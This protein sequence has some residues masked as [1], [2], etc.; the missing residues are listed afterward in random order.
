[1]SAS[2]FLLPAISR[3][4]QAVNHPLLVT[5]K[6]SAGGDDD[7]A[8]DG[9]SAKEDKNIQKLIAKFMAAKGDENDEED[10][11]DID[12]NTAAD[13]L[14]RIESGETHMCLFC[15]EEAEAEV[16]LPCYHTG[17]V[18][19]PN[20]ISQSVN[21]IA[22]ASCRDCATAYIEKEEDFDRVPTCPQCKKPF[23]ARDLRESKK[24]PTGRLNFGEQATALAKVDFQTSTKLK[25]L[26]RK[27]EQ[28][29]VQD[30]KYKALVFSQVSNTEARPFA[31]ALMAPLTIVY[32]D[33]LTGRA[34]AI[35]QRCRL[36]VSISARRCRDCL[37]T[38]RALS[39]FDGSMNQKERASVIEAFGK[40]ST[41]PKVLLISLK[42]G[43]VGLNL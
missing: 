21:L 24:K 39:R 25:A 30:P 32:V 7:A 20:L 42:A 5:S 10:I 33:A 13:T 19:L 22:M 23:K 27:L 1:M 40:P 6:A 43:G 37:L 16:I 36:S 9:L 31:L 2:T 26:I 15:Q 12:A 41:E 8:S 4:R 18:F 28:I 29:K 35:R 14:K 3:L 11:I 34:R 17:Y 38:G